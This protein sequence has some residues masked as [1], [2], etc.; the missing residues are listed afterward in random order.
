MTWLLHPPEAAPTI[1]V[2]PMS[3]HDRV[4]DFA[5]EAALATSL[6]GSPAILV[7]L[8]A[9]ETGHKHDKRTA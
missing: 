3:E 1:P 7:S 9:F 5:T 6:D 8:L 4:R 2:A